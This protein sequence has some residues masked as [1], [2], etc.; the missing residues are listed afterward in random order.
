M[1]RRI[2]EADN[3]PVETDAPEDAAGIPYDAGLQQQLLELGPDTLAEYGVLVV[4]DVGDEARYNSALWYALGHDLQYALRQ[5]AVY[6]WDPV[7]E[8]SP[9][10]LPPL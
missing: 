6:I 1:M 5:G 9:P 7:D 2:A 3:A 8:R 4:R 10:P